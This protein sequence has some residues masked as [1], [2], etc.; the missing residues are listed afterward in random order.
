M[1]LL[2]IKTSCG[3]LVTIRVGQFTPKG[4]LS[5]LLIEGSKIDS[6]MFHKL[7]QIAHQI[8]SWNFKVESSLQSMSL[9]TSTHFTF[10]YSCIC[11]NVHFIDKI[12]KIDKKLILNWLLDG[13]CRIESMKW[14]TLMKRFQLTH[15]DATRRTRP[16]QMQ[17]VSH[18]IS[19]PIMSS[20]LTSVI[21]F[22]A[23]FTKV[24]IPW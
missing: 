1:N 15:L 11:T 17:T 4:R 23:Y 18:S 24:S 10:R 8:L 16:Y 2:I 22:I 6:S 20:E 9:C 13:T 5:R 19:L 3:D 21:K 7:H 14:R 12:D